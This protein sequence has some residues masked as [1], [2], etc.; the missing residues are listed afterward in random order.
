MRVPSAERTAS[1]DDNVMDVARCGVALPGD[2]TQAVPQGVV[3]PGRRATHPPKSPPSLLAEN[4]RDSSRPV[5][6]PSIVPSLLN[7][8][9]E[10]DEREARIGSSQRHHGFCRS[11]TMTTTANDSELPPVGDVT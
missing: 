3:E 7:G 10:S 4:F 8:G 2:L 11:S 5:N 1:M 9:L 6:R